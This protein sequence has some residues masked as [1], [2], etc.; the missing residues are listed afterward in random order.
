MIRKQIESSELR[1]PSKA[2]CHDS[3]R[4][5]F[6]LVKGQVEPVK[7]EEGLGRLE[8]TTTVA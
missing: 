7:S 8:S 4:H 1:A 2:K 3:Q 6:G 5:P